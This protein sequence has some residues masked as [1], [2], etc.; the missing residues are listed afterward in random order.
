MRKNTKWKD[1]EEILTIL[2]TVGECETGIAAQKLGFTEGALRSRLY[3]IRKRLEQYQWLLN[4]VRNMQRLNPRIRKLTTSG[5]LIKETGE[6][7]E[8]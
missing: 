6:T 4:N 5:T 1:G 8:E 2:K 3:R 7:E